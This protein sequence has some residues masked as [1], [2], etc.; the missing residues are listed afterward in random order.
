M[1]LKEPKTLNSVSSEFSLIVDSD[2]NL[3]KI[4]RIIDDKKIQ[5][6][7]GIMVWNSKTKQ[8]NYTESGEIKTISQLVDKIIESID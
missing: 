4:V 5:H 7:L 2:K 6:E 3:T 8:I 1:K